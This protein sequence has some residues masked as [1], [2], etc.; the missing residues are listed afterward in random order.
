MNE[1]VDYTNFW[2][3]SLNDAIEHNLMELFYAYIDA[4]EDTDTEPYDV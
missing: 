1:T 2:Y 4:I 3:D